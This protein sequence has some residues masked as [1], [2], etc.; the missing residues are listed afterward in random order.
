MSVFHLHQLFSIQVP[1]ANVF[2]HISH[3]TVLFKH[4]KWPEGVKNILY[5]I[6]YFLPLAHTKVGLTL[7][8]AKISFLPKKVNDRLSLK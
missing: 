6:Y 5:L 4:L 1:Y 7:D 2:T 3:N 8:P